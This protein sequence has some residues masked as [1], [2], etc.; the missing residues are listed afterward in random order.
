MS[1][2]TSLMEMTRE[3]SGESP[4]YEGANEVQRAGCYVLK[5]DLYK[6]MAKNDI[7]NLSAGISA[8]AKSV[9][10]NEDAIILTERAPER[11][12]MSIKQ[13]EKL[14][15]DIRSASRSKAETKQEID[16]R[17]NFLKGVVKRM[18][19]AKEGTD[20][21]NEHVKF[22][23]KG[24]I[25]FNGLARLIDQQH[26]AFGFLANFAELVIPGGSLIVRAVTYKNMMDTQIKKTNA[27]IEYLENQK[28]NM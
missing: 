19:A 11:D 5:E 3:V 2:Y 24:L 25:P 6:F 18:E 10:I 22:V 9:K 26:D 28:K 7:T 16:A 23:L 15:N 21:N 1:L 17:I 12:A 8:Y 14:L 13:A 20:G 4:V 27:T